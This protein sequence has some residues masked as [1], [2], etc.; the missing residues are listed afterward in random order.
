MWAQTVE[1]ND[2]GGLAVAGVSVAALKEQFGTPLF[3]MDEEDFR[4]R[5]RAFKDSFDAAFA[6]ICGGVDV[7]YAGKSFLCTA[8]VKWVEE[9]GLRLDTS[10]GGELAVAA[11]AGIPGER[12]ALHGNNKSDAEINRALD[13]K[14]GRIVVDSLAE[15]DSRFIS[16]DEEAVEAKVEGEIRAVARMDA[17][18]GADVD[19]AAGAR[20]HRAEQEQEHAIL[21]ILGEDAE[22]GVPD[23]RQ[24]LAARGDAAIRRLE[25]PQPDLDGRRCLLA[26]RPAE[27]E[28]VEPRPEQGGRR[29]SGS[30]PEAHT[31][32]SA[33]TSKS[34]VTA[35]SEAGREATPEF[36]DS[37][38]SICAPLSTKS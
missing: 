28:V 7:Y 26:Q 13:M 27:Q 11:R 24:R 37:R 5:A 31:P 30:P 19:E 3:V 14:L 12:V 23:P 29:L 1:R 33:L 38:T 36:G 35:P 9:E 2:D 21:V 17:V 18:A 10:S 8:V 32:G 20:P 22:A 16:V 34:Q 6:D 15:L 25:A 4:S